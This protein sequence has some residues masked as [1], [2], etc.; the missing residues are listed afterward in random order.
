MWVFGL[1][2][3]FYD[4]LSKFLGFRS[5]ERLDVYGG[6][7]YPDLGH[8]GMGAMIALV[9]LRLWV[10]RAHLAAV[11]RRAFGR[12]TDADDAHEPLS[13]AAAFW[14]AAA[15]GLVMLLWLMA[16]GFSFFIALVVLAAAFI[17]FVGLTRVIAEIG[18]PTSIVPLITSDF[19]VSAVGTSAIGPKGL[20]AMPWT[21]V[22][23]GDV[24]TFVMCSAA[25]GMRACSE[26]RRGYRGLPAAML[27]AAVLAMAVSIPATIHFAHE[28]GGI[29]MAPW[30]FNRHPH[31]AFGFIG[32]LIQQKPRPPDG[33]GWI[34][35]AIGAG[36][37]VLFSFARHAFVWWPLNP[38]ALPIAAV[39]WTHWLWLSFLIAWL[40][41]TRVLKYGG[42]KLYLKLKP[43]FLGLVL[44]Q[45]AGAALWQAVDAVCGVQGNIIFTI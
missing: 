15:G 45:Y 25:H 27:L 29:N 16:T 31:H 2:G 19:T 17:G 18:V 37:M 30:Y 41:K 39:S 4:G 6:A 40:I 7:P 35:T 20:V 8:F 21:Y 1:G 24:R 5:P 43:F 12:P 44:G 38:V 36:A 13:Y 28:E 23:D 32:T 26:R 10:G 42:A 3:S 22:W 14:G 34:A 11:L 33:R 9:L